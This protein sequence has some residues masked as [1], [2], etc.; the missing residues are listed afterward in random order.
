M[1][2]KDTSIYLLGII[3]LGTGEYNSP[4]GGVGSTII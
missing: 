1:P 3:K 2:I 4:V